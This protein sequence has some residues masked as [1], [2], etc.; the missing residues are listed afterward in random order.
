LAEQG[1]DVGHIL[2]TSD[3]MTQTQVEDRL[4]ELADLGGEDLLMRPW[5]ERLAEAYRARNRKAAY[6]RPRKA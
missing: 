4:L 5:A 3:I 6:A 2:A 1:V